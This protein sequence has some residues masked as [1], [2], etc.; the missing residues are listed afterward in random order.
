MASWFTVR[1]Y[2]TLVSHKQKFKKIQNAC[3][4]I[5]Y[6]QVQFWIRLYNSIPKWVKLQ[7]IIQKQ[8]IKTG[9]TDIWHLKSLN[10]WTNICYPV[11]EHY[12][13][14]T[15]T[16]ITPSGSYATSNALISHRQ[17]TG[18]PRL[19]WLAILGRYSY[20]NALHWTSG[21]ISVSHLGQASVLPW[22][23]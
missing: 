19:H 14:Q 21:L 12:E 5:A 11:Q 22:G 9:T 8:T 13:T 3:Q 6:N 23:R 20:W 16:F 1:I 2:D 4:T 18:S 7:N 10:T 17:G 15:Q